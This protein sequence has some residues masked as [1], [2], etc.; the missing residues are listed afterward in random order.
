MGV[1]YNHTLHLTEITMPTIEELMAENA[2]LRSE[3]AMLNYVATHGKGGGD[4][5]PPLGKKTLTRAHFEAQTAVERMKF[6]RDGEYSWSTDR[7]RVFTFAIAT[8][9][10]WPNRATP[11]SCALQAQACRMACTVAATTGTEGGTGR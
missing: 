5:T 8:S 6:M 10:R 9:R 7:C 11:K 4:A 2:E 1:S 3:L